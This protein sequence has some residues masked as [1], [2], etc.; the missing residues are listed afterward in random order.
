MEHMVYFYAELG[1]AHYETVMYTPS[2]L[3]ASSVYAAQRALSRK[4]AWDETLKAYT[5]Y[6]EEKLQ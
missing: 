2:Q 3:A 1:M 5:G 4:P 6:S